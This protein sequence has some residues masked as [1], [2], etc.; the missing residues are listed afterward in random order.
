[1]CDLVELQYAR[2][3]ALQERAVV[4]DDHGAAGALLDEPLQPGEAVEVEVVGGLVEQEHV[5]AGE[6]DRGER[7]A[8]GLATRQRRR[9]QVEQRRVEAEVAQHGLCARLQVGAAEAE[10]GLEGLGVAVGRAVRV[11][12]HGGGRLLHARVRRRHPGPAREVLLHALAGRAVGL[13]RQV[14]RDAGR[15]PHR[16]LV[17][18]VDAGEDPQQRRLTGPVRPDDAEHVTRRDG[19][20]HAGKH[21][22]RAVRL[23]DLPRD[24]R[25]GHGLAAYEGARKGTVP[26]LAPQARFFHPG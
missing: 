19:H 8:R 26:F 4:G 3:G 7:G 24:Q 13:L 25:P 10:P 1:M 20:R 11:R 12:G 6:Q 14:A 16:A 18:R 23:L 17:G 2:D 5:E 9:L 22:V 15:E 21:G